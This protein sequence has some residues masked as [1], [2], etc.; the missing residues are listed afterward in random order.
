MCKLCFK[1]C[2]CIYICRYMCVLVQ[3]SFFVF[4]LST[5]FVNSLRI[6]YNIF[7]LDPLLT[8]NSSRFSPTF[9]STQ[10]CVLS[11]KIS[12]HGVQFLLVYYSWE[13][14]LLW[15]VV[16]MQSITPLKKTDFSSL[17][18]NHL[19]IEPWVHMELHA[20]C[21]SPCLDFYLNWAQT[22]LVHAA[23]DSVSSDVHLE[24]LCLEV[25]HH[26]CILQSFCPLSFEIWGKG[27]DMLINILGGN[28]ANRHHMLPNKTQV[29]GWVASFD[30]WGSPKIFNITS[31]C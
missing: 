12:A 29:P 3:E 5:V 24:V 17:S 16:D 8:W 31:Y 1:V 18:N 13:W 9:V 2:S 11:L 28:T 15:S 20:H 21:L 10:L 30:L 14:S 23:T 22:C 25:F 4:I 27:Y 19:P 6:S 26:L 7:E